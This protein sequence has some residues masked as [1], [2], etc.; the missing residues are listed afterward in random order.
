MLVDG[1]VLCGFIGVMLRVENEHC[2]IDVGTG[3]WDTLDRKNGA[4][5]KYRCSMEMWHRSNAVPRR[6]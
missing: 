1:I 2:K 3:R 5:E 4:N 6:G